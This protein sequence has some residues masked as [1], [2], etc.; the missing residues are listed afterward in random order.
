MGKTGNKTNLIQIARRLAPYAVIVFFVAVF[1][2]SYWGKGLIP[3]PSRYLVTFFPPWS[4]SYGMPVKNAAMPDVITQI[5]PWK[6]FT[7][8]T[9][10]RKEVPLWNPYSFSGTAH[11]GNYQTAVFSPINLLF[12]LLSEIDAWSIMILLQPLIA[13][14]G[15][16]VFLRRIGRS[17][18]SSVLGSLS[19]MFCGFIVVWMEYG[20]L[21]YTISVLPFDL[22]VATELI[23]KKT[24]WSGPLL[25][26]V[27]AFSF[28]SGHFQM[29]LYFFF[30]LVGYC[31]ATFYR[32]GEK[33]NGMVP[34]L[35]IAVG[36]AIALP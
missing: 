13:G 10:K 4:A 5:Y 15:T 3:F 34:L 30:Y 36:L 24:Y 9:W 23:E 16:Y 17:V 25:A 31:I 28:L 2:F 1:S 8:E 35:Y 11:A 22:Y 18:V 26:F 7:I 20:T 6:R 21:G 29:S 32:V 27:V 19:W 12:F 33:R 14:L